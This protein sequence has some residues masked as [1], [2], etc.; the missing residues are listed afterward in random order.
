MVVGVMV[1]DRT[2]VPVLFPLPV[3]VQEGLWTHPSATLGLG[4]N[5]T[6]GV[7]VDFYRQHYHGLHNEG[8][9]SMERRAGF[10][11]IP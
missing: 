2:C 1:G 8:I 6:A 5:L 3:C 7:V 4:Q 11:V 9:I 10:A